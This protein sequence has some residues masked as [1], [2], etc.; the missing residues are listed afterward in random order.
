M[1]KYLFA[2]FALLLALGIGL[3]RN[4]PKPANAGMTV[5]DVQEMVKSG[6]SEDLIIAALRKDN[7]R[8]DLGAQDMLALK[9]AGVSDNIIKVMLD[10]TAPVISPAVPAAGGAP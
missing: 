7:H 1:T 10:P 5:A 2:T 6:L 3:A 8:F 9:K 4:P